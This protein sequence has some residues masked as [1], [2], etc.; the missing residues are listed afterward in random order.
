MRSVR[1]ERIIV[2]REIICNFGKRKTLANFGNAKNIVTL[3]SSYSLDIA[4]RNTIT[5]KYNV[6][7]IACSF[8]FK[9][10]R[11]KVSSIFEDRQNSP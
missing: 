9:F 6:N 10:K 2:K 8:H 11:F 1:N 4:R 7:T 5:L 3:H